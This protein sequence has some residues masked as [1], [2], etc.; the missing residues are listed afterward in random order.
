MIEYAENLDFENAAIIRDK[1]KFIEN[2]EIGI[3]KKI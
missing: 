2:K 3:K 1:I